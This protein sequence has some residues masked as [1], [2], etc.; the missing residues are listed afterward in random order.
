[1]AFQ[2]LIQ[3]HNAPVTYNVTIQEEDVYH[4]RLNEGQAKS[5]EAYIP[6]KLVIRKKGKIWVSDLEDYGEL[7]TSLTKEI[8]NFS[9]DKLSA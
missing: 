4:F 6:E 1:M 2:I 5:G 9:N 7:V 8:K 3:Y